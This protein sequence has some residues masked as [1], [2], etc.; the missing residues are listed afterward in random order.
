MY[1]HG[2]REEKAPLR[3]SCFCY[4]SVSEFYS[5][6]SSITELPDLLV[7]HVLPAHCTLLPVLSW[8]MTLIQ[9]DSLCGLGG[10]PGAAAAE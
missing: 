3:A 7:L 1:I 8:F 4:S 9:W 5:S 10:L 6:S 2:Q